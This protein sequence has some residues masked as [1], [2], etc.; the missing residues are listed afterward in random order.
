MSRLPHD[1]DLYELWDEIAGFDAARHEAALDH[2]MTRLC[3][4]VGAH[5]AICI[6]AVRMPDILADDPLRGWRV[7]LKRQLREVASFADP[8]GEVTR[9]ARAGDSDSTAARNVA[10]AGCWR[11]NRLVDLVGAAW[12]ESAFYRDFYLA[13][14]LGDA[15]WGVC[16]VNED[17]EVYIGVFRPADGSRFG[18]KERDN[19][20]AAMRGLKWYFRQLLLS[21]GLCLAKAP[22]TPLEC[23]VL[24]GLLG[25]GTESQIAGQIGHSAHTTHEYVK[26]IYRKFGVTNRPALTALWLG[27][28]R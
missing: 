25:G 13:G 17:A 14:N 12:F 19:V 26:R 9:R 2:L 6:G 10:M 24:Q 8:V 16:P 20:G 15:I 28:N 23:D 3:R 7:G 11:F 27:K 4:R 1:N 5:N 18:E 22:L 21:H